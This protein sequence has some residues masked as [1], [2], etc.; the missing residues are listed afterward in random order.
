MTKFRGTPK[1]LLFRKAAVD[2]RTF[3]LTDRNLEP[4]APIPHFHFNWDHFPQFQM[5]NIGQADNQYNWAVCGV[6][7]CPDPCFMRYHTMVDYQLNDESRPKK[8]GRTWWKT[9]DWARKP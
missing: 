9:E 1:M 4:A 7:M 5:A 8:T 6:N 3:R 2:G